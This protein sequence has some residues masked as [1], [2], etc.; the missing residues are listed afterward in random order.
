MCK[1][2]ESYFFINVSEVKNLKIIH[3]G[4]EGDAGLEGE[5]V[6]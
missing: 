2:S 5:A 6:V 1:Y 4:L 3:G